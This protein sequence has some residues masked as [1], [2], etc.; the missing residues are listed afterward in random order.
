M[1]L[2]LGGAHFESLQPTGHAYRGV[3]ANTTPGEGDESTHRS[4]TIG[5]QFSDVPIDFGGKIGVQ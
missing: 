2:A 3:R 5:Q 1:S 4:Q